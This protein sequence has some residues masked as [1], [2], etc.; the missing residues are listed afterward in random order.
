MESMLANRCVCKSLLVT[1]QSVCD[2][3]C[4]CISAAPESLMECLLQTFMNAHGIGEVALAG[5]TSNLFAMLADCY[6][7]SKRVQ[8]GDEIIILDSSH[9]VCPSGPYG[10]PFAIKHLSMA[11]HQK[12]TCPANSPNGTPLLLL[13]I[14]SALQYARQQLLILCIKQVKVS[15]VR[16]CLHTLRLLHICWMSYVCGCSHAI[17]CMMKPVCTDFY[18]STCP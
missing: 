5:A 7:R 17:A 13:T 3:A 10:H 8:A 18:S 11:V 4:F 1:Y 9:E 12:S 14:I 2:D 16:S 15:V 6:R